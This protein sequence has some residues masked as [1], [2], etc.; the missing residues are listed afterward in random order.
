[1]QT[2]VSK[3]EQLTLYHVSINCFMWTFVCKQSHLFTQMSAWLKPLLIQVAYWKC[4]TNNVHPACCRYQDSEEEWVAGSENQASSPPDSE[5]ETNHRSSSPPA[6]SST[7]VKAVATSTTDECSTNSVTVSESIKGKKWDKQHACKFCHKMVIKMSDHLERVHKNE[8]EVARVL[9]MKKGSRERR[10]A[11]GELLRQGDFLHNYEVL[12]ANTG[13]FI[14]KYISQK[15]RRPKDFVPCSVCKGM[16]KRNLLGLHIQRCGKVHGTPVP[17]KRKAAIIEGELLCPAASG[18]SKSF[19]QKVLGKMK[20]DGVKRIVLNDTLIL[21][22]GERL[23]M[24][25]DIHEHTPNHISSRLRLLGRVMSALRSKTQT[26]KKRIATLTEALHPANFNALLQAVKEVCEYD[27]D[28]H[29]YRKGSIALKIGYS[30]KRCNAVLK[31]EAAK[32][33]NSALKEQAAA[34]EAAF[35]GD[36]QDFVSTCAVQSV[37]TAKSNKPKLLP[38]CADVEKL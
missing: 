2:A 26:D 3:D 24:K 18:T 13:V 4:T 36:W 23:F 8:V 32:E 21:Q 11:W 37:D 6:S 5:E 17:K 10:T 33:G 35:D 7:V 29:M 15:E 12:R 22:Y 31:S 30:L 16:Y 9:A 1:M 19:F 38:S 34:F 27:D 14:P 20:D 28:A 25:K